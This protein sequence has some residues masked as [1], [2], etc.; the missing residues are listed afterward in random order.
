M[1][2]FK[3]TSTLVLIISVFV[4]LSAC[5]KTTDDATQNLPKTI[6]GFTP[7]GWKLYNTVKQFTPEN[8]YEHI[9]GR[10]EFYIAYD[11]A[12]MT[13]ANFMK[14]DL[15]GPFIDLFIYDMGNVTNGFGVFSAERSLEGSPLQLG[16]EAYRQGANYYIW[17]GRYYIT[18][19]AS[20]TSSELETIG[21][22][23]AENISNA[24][25]DS[26]EK[27]WG[28]LAMPQKDMIAG[29][30]KYVK[31]DAMGLDFMKNAYM[32]QYHIYNTDIKHF[33]SP[34][35]SEKIAKNVIKQYAAFAK[36]Y[37]NGAE[38]KTING[39]DLLICDMED[40]YDVVF[41]KGNLVAG[42]LS[43]KEKELAVKAAMEM[44]NQ[45]P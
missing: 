42:A 43:V 17:K 5:A 32:A 38:T 24:L 35:K 19:I 22:T 37:G 40:Y 26:E 1:K 8:L 10:A 33:L 12:G 16:R 30:I 28:L 23:L 4:F 45:L 27:V 9:N 18:I 6:L 2:S 15:K 13:F 29:S 36:Q 31:S 44:H 3:I 11:V 7:Q 41:Q 25:T 21:K 20:E 39:T 14:D 34:S